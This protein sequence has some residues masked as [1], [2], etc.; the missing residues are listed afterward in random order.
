MRSPAR[1]I[2]W[3][4]RQQHRWGWIALASYFVIMATFK[5]L[6][7]GVGRP[8]DWDDVRF[9]L[10]VVVPL[11]T[12]FTY[13][14]AVFTFGLSGDLA[15]RQSMFPPRRFTLPVTTAALAGWPMLYG[16]AAI[17]ILWL[18]TRVFA[19]WPAGF[20]IPTVWPAFLA[21]ALLAWTQALTWMPYPLPG[22]RV[23]ATVLWLA[24]IDSIVLLALSFNAHEPVML[25]ILAPQVP[26]AYLAARSAVARARRGDVPDWSGFFVRRSIAADA[27]T[28]REHFPSPT[29]AQRWF[30]WRLHGRSLPAL[31]G[32]LLPFELAILPVAGGRPA[33]IFTILAGVL[34]TPPAMA[35]FAAATVRQ[36]NPHA[37][38]SHG[39]PPFVATRPLSSAA[40]VAAKLKA[41]MWSTLAAWLLVIVAIPV[42]LRLTDTAPVVAD[43]AGRFINA[44]GTPRA[45]VFAALGL[46]TLM[47]S[48]WKQLVQSLY[49]GL[50][51]R[52]RVIKTSLLLTLLALAAMGPIAIWLIESSRARAALWS[53]IPWLLAVLVGGKMAAASWVAIHLQRSR[54][55]SDRTLVTGAA[56]WVAAVLALYGLLTWLLFTPFMPRYLLG[57]IAIL[58]IPLA[59]LAAAPL[60]L[61]WNRHR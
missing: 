34:L 1:A 40:L 30:E 29:H 36:P 51:G 56:A 61:A 11:A 22:L 53:A 26:L 59:R 54:V 60:A 2:A 45:I 49:I 12:T 37:G 16:S 47:A 21:A 44:V 18:A 27:P 28:R 3:E 14:L 32:I 6:I 19:V 50:T 25:A 4:F 31:V 10:V 8:G 24:A 13:L 39:L 46:G 38:D 35:A 58:M 52:A 33:L 7:L 5:F 41:A 9:A 42:A 15:A 17:A 43:R 23:I 48:T 57:L 20:E 55:L